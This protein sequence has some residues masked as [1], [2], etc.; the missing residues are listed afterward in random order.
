MEPHIR[1]ITAPETRQLRHQVLRPR[2]APETLVYPGD[3][4]P[5][6][7]HLGAFQDDIMVGI[8]SIAPEACPAL[9]SL[10]AWRL[11]GMATVPLVQRQGYGAALIHAG[12]AHVRRH[13]GDIL[14]CHGRT[15]ALPFYQALGF[16]A[17]G[18]V[19]SVPE[20]GPH[21][22]LWRAVE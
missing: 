9:P 4:H 22:L 18:D 8:A 21:V 1:A 17:V 16:V 7:L 3:D 14:W 19:F 13:D 2:Q 11:R 5:L 12:I 20:T 6:C 15:T 10:A